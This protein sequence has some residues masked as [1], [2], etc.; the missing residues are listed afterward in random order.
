[1]PRVEYE[2]NKGTEQQPKQHRHA[3][4]HEPESIRL[5]G[6]GLRTEQHEQANPYDKKYR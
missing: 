1:M 3:H 2:P 4:C 5:L 6:Q